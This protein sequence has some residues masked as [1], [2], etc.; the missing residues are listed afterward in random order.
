MTAQV[1]IEVR[2]IEKVGESIRVLDSIKHK[3]E[4]NLSMYEEQTL[5]EVI[6]ILIAIGK[7]GRTL[8]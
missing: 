1:K 5:N 4:R 3:G 6:S 8:R 7:A 2:N